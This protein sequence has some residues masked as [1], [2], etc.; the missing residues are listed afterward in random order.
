MNLVQYIGFRL[1]EAIKMLLSGESKDEC[2]FY[3]M[4][5]KKQLFGRDEVIINEDKGKYLPENE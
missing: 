1:D 2:A 3:L 4:D 5:F